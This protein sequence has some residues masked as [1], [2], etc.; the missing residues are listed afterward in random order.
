MTISVPVKIQRTA[1]DAKAPV[2]MERFEVPYF[3]QMDII[4]VLRYIRDHIDPTLAF[5]YSCEEGKCGLCGVQVN[6]RPVLACKRVVSPGENLTIAPLAGFP[7]IKDLLVDRSAY[8]DEVLT[9]RRTA[10][11]RGKKAQTTEEPSLDKYIALSNC[12]ECG[13]CSSTC[14]AGLIG[15]HQQAGPVGFLES[16]RVAFSDQLISPAG[17]ADLFNCLECGQCQEL[18]SRDVA[19]P[20]L[21]AQA[22]NTVRNQKMW[23]KGTLDVVERVEQGEVL[24]ARSVHK[25][26]SGWLKKAD[27]EV[28]DRIGKKD[29]EVGVYVGCQYGLRSNLQDVPNRLARLLLA[30]GVDFTILGPEEK[31]CGHP[32][33]AVG[34]HTGVRR[35]AERN[36]EAFRKLNIKTLVVGCPGCYRAWSFEYPRELGGPTGL[37]VLH[38]SEFLCNLLK[39][40]RLNQTY[41]DNRTIV[42]HDPCELGRLSQLYEPPR[43]VLDS[44]PEIR[45]KNLPRER[46]MALCCGGGGLIPSTGDRITAQVSALR[47]EDVLETEA[48]ALV[49]ACPNCE[50]TLLTRL[51]SVGRSSKP[52]VQDIVDLV[53][54]S[55][56]GTDEW[57]GMESVEVGNPPRE[58]S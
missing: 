1:V 48:D 55:V 31:C 38:T 17:S 43:A 28:L 14:P 12:V 52:V 30:A 16:V 53:Y 36:I 40:G 23:P 10:A 29:S 35:A 45:R 56:F 15:V 44:I 34:S 33:N 11:G 2:R 20:E 4:D 19:V 22:R 37:K 6:D 47:V 8:D 21:V 13:V 7:V 39:D 58:W 41:S 46:E 5:R 26:T 25:G 9:Q 24:L 57:M 49:T 50:L 27:G 3:D 54:T 42:Y 32:C 18:C 51:R